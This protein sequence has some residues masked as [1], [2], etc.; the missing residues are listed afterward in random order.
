[1]S[2]SWDAFSLAVDPF[3]LSWSSEASPGEY[4][5]TRDR[6]LLSSLLPRF[7]FFFPFHY[8]KALK[9]PVFAGGYGFF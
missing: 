1:M 2:L 6:V 8:V 4:L 5:D 7:I 3:L 9:V